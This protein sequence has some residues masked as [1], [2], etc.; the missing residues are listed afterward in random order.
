MEL[1]E[2]CTVLYGMKDMVPVVM[3]IDAHQHDEEPLLLVSPQLDYVNDPT[4]FLKY[5]FCYL[6]LHLI[7]YIEMRM[8]QNT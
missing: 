3:V 8:N 4:M 1:F 2:S 6:Q 7:A 5:W